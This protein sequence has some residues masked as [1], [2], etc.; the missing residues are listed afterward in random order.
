VTSL[1]SRC[2][3]PI[4]VEIPF[5]AA[6]RPDIDWQEAAIC[7][8]AD[9]E[10]FFPIGTS[11]AEIQRP[12]AVCARCP[13]RRPSLAY[14]LATRQEF[15]IWGGRDENERRLLHLA[16]EIAGAGGDVTQA[17]ARMLRQ[18]SVSRVRGEP[19]PIAL[20]RQ[21]VRPGA[22]SPVSHGS[23]K[24][25]NSGVSLL[26]QPSWLP[27]L[28]NRIGHLDSHL[29]GRVSCALSRNLTGSRGASTR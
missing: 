12:K 22:I 8:Q 1:T 10:L 28:P 13:V 15:G 4:L 26:L 14:A 9:P 20:G 23:T 7:R 17:L 19:S 16:A 18:V 24:G 6:H 29:P 2:L 27:R 11:G 25:A 5:P 21:I 3:P